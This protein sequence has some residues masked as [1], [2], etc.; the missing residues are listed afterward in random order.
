MLDKR[1]VG[2]LSTKEGNLLIGKGVLDAVA[3]LLAHAVD[4][5]DF[6]GDGGFDDRVKDDELSFRR[7][8]KTNGLGSATS[9]VIAV[10]V[11]H[12]RKL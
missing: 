3:R 2:T 5:G 4:D 7:L 6:D 1:W 9:D 12:T 11:D 8:G 10:L